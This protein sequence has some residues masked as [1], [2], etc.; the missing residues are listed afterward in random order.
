MQ[1]HHVAGKYR[2]FSLKSLISS[3]T[4]A[5][6]GALFLSNPDGHETASLQD[7]VSEIS[8]EV[9][10]QLHMVIMKAARRTLLD[11][12]V[13]HAIS[14]CISEKK[15]LKKAANQKKVTNQKKVINQ[16]VKMSS[17][18]TRMVNNVQAWNRSESN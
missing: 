6:P 15:D 12:I 4:T 14:E 2:P 13:S 17:P 7:F 3:W 11:E 16:S 1:V 5:T 10:S 9:C 8:Q 18:G